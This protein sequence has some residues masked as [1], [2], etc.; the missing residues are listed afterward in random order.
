MYETWVSKKVTLLK[1]VC[2]LN[3]YII[4]AVIYPFKTSTVNPIN[5]NSNLH[6]IFRN[7]YNLSHVIKKQLHGIKSDYFM[8]HIIQ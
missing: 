5:A 7:L 4:F 2:V 3:A 6:K 1:C 8:S